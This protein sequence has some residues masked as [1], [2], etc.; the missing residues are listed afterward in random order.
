MKKI[1]E[2]EFTVKFTDEIE[3]DEETKNE[4]VLKRIN[5][6]P[7]IKWGKNNKNNEWDE[8]DYAK[9]E[10]ET[11]NGFYI[12]EITK[13]RIINAIMN[14]RFINMSGMKLKE[15]EVESR[16]DITSVFN[17]DGTYCSLDNLN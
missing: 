3:M 8:L 15:G 9:F 14:S 1:F 11:E 12:K 4:V 17:E 10:I 5:I 6:N 13:K 7:C 16:L 2:W